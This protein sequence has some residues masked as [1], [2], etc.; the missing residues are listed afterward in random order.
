MF[1]N[2]ARPYRYIPRDGVPR[3]LKHLAQDDVEG[4]PSFRKTMKA[5]MWLPW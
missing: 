3:L 5:K 2:E 4:C 1:A